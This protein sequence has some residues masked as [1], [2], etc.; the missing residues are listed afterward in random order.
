MA[1]NLPPRGQERDDTG[2]MRRHTN[3]ALNILGWCTAIGSG[4]AVVYGLY[5]AVNG[6]PLNNDT[7]AFFNVVHR[8]VWAIGFINTFLS[9]K[10]WIPIGRLTYCTYLVHPVIMYVYFY[11]KRTLLYLTDMDV[12]FLFMGQLLIGYAAGFVV[13]LAFEAPMMGLEKVIFRREKKS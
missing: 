10:G 2:K 12:A 3:P 6:H 5:D 7:S 11:H 9:W 13:S 8:N 1:Q 4:K